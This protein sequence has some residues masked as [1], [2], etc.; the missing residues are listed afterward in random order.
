MKLLKLLNLSLIFA[1]ASI[2]FAESALPKAELPEE[3]A[4]VLKTYETAW[5]AGDSETIASL[6]LADGLLLPNKN[7]PVE[8][9]QSIQA[10]YAGGG[11]P[12][13]FHAYRYKMSGDL[14]IVIGGITIDRVDHDLGKFTLTLEKTDDGSWKIISDMENRNLE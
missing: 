9:R 12:L 4:K 1:F 10:Y 3:L 7:L 14:A 13:R 6:F 5:A 11:A 2:T 8:G